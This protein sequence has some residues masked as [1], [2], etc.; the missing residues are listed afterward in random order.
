MYNET[1]LNNIESMTFWAMEFATDRE[2]WAALCKRAKNNN[3]AID[4]A[5][6]DAEARAALSAKFAINYCK[7]AGL[8]PETTLSVAVNFR[9]MV[10]A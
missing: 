10:S 3:Q 5:I 4:K 1:Q 6:K 8:E 7:D 2:A 9:K